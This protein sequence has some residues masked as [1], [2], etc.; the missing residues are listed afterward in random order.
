MRLIAAA[1]TLCLAA[2]AHSASV[3]IVERANIDKSDWKYSVGWDGVTLPSDVFGDILPVNDTTS[4][5]HLEVRPALAV[6]FPACSEQAASFPQRRTAGGVYIC[7]DIYW[8]GHCGY[9]VQPLG[10][11][12][13]LGSEWADKISSFGPDKCTTCLAWR[14]VLCTMDWLST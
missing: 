3:A 7:T 4:S 11:C 2:T 12:I 13:V 1:F 9:A 14:Y 10:V 8:G 5:S 6:V